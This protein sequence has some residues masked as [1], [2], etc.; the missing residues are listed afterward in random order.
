LRFLWNWSNRKRP[1]I[2]S[3]TT[4]LSILT[5]FLWRARNTRFILISS[6]G[7]IFNALPG[8]LKPLVAAVPLAWPSVGLAR[9]GEVKAGF[10]PFLRNSSWRYSTRDLF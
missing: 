7:C 5:F 9:L 8:T 4:T 3:E 10:R 1:L 2:V 6:Q